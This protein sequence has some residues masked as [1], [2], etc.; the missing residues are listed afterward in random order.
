LL[1]SLLSKGVEQWA[2][3][4]PLVGNTNV[5][6]YRDLVENPLPSYNHG[7]YWDI[8]KRY[9]RDFTAITVEFSIPKYWYGHNVHLL[10]GWYKALQHFRLWFG[11]VLGLGRYRLPKIDTWKVKRCDLCYAWRLGDQ[12]QADA[13]I[14]GLKRLNY[15]WKKPRHY[16]GTALWKGSTYSAK[17]Y[18]KYPEFR[19][20]STKKLIKAGADPEWVESWERKAE[21]VVR[22]E[23]TG[24]AQWLKR[25]NIETV[26]DLIQ[27]ISYCQV[28]PELLEWAKTLNASEPERI[29]QMLMPMLIK[30]GYIEL[31]PENGISIEVDKTIT[32]P[33][34]RSPP[35]KPD[36][37]IMVVPG[38]SIISR[39]IDRPTYLLQEYLKK[40]V[41]D[42]DMSMKDQV[43]EKLKQHYSDAKAL[44][45]MGFWLYAREFGLD[46]AKAMYTEP[47][48]YRNRSDIKKA[49]VNIVEKG[50]RLVKVDFKIQVPSDRVVN[51]YDDFRT[52]ANILNFSGNH[53]NQA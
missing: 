52:H 36:G 15:P 29:L 50:D 49:G 47:T 8:P 53:R 26:A 7:I 45:L 4:Q 18:A 43:L 25:Q 30:E 20:N 1:D 51:R 27:P 3:W 38:G 24:R 34:L 44:R 11:E 22:F 39:V 16:S 48:Y 23:I 40:L 9:Y 13:F 14:N 28:T 21:G 19:A 35:L 33:E 31:T 46:E 32:F 42:G 10:Y 2:I 5:L 17:F 41:G 37:S 6:R 12:E